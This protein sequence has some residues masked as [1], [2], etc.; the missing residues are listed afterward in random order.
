MPTNH[1]AMTRREL[2][3]TG[4][5]A[6]AVAGFDAPTAAAETPST[7]SERRADWVA[8]LDRVC[9]PLFA[10]LAERKLKKVMPV[11]AHA[12]EEQHRRHTTYLEALGRALAGIAPW[13][14]HGPDAG[15]EGEIR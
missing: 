12:G 8:M 7:F 9:H 13:L 3:L 11:E 15:P 14:E 1:F 10:A 5:A 6:G 4:L 2:L